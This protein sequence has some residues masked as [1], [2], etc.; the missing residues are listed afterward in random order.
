MPNKVMPLFILFFLL[1]SSVKVSAQ[2]LPAATI[3]KVK[4]VN[5]TVEFTVASSSAFYV[6]NNIFILRIG[7]RSFDLSRQEN[8][9][10]KGLLTFLIPA[11]QY[12]SLFEGEKIFL[13]YGQLLPDESVDSELME[14][15]SRQPDACQHL[16]YFHE[17]LLSK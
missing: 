1:L 15:C 17:K 7:K 3:K 16:G 9:D 13:T 4:Q 12:F 8:I 14:V 6:G 11:D 5:N 2:A 10:D